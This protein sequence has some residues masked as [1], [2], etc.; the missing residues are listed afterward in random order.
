[1]INTLGR[2]SRAARRRAV[3]LLSMLGAVLT[4]ALAGAGAASATTDPS[5]VDPKAV[6]FDPLK[7]EFVTVIV[8]A[9]AAI[10]VAGIVWRMVRKNGKQAASDT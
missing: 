9:L 2:K 6:V 4:L 8:P 3:L 1:L 7:S 5:G 10:L